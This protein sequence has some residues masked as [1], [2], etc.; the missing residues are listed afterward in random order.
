M[1]E[2]S[3]FGLLLRSL[4]LGANLTLEALSVR[5]GVSERTIGDLERGASTSPQRRTVDALA[6]GLGL[7]VAG[8]HAFLRAARARPRHTVAPPLPASVAPHRVFD[9][10]GRTEEIQQALEILEG[11]PASGG[12]RPALVISG[13]PGIGKT[14]GALEILARSRLTEL[15]TVFVSLDGFSAA[16]LTPLQIITTMLRQL[17]GAPEQPATDLETAA[18]QWRAA[19]EISP[20]RILLDNAANESQVRPIL[21]ICAGD[22]LVVTSRRSLAGLEGVR[23]LRFGPLRRRD[24]IALLRHLMPQTD[25]DID[26]LNEIASLCDDIPLALRVVGNRIASRPGWTVDDLLRRMRTSEDRLRLL[27]AGDL[28]VE[29]AISL[30]YEEL[31][32]RTAALFRW[33]SLIDGK[34]FTA[35]LAAVT[36]DSTEIGDVE[37]RLDDLTDLG[38]LEARGGDRYRLHDLLRLF[39][40]NRLGSVATDEEIEERRT[41]VGSWVLGTLERAG[42]WFEP[43]REPRGVA[44]MG[45][46]FITADSAG[47]WIRSEAEHWWPAYVDAAEHGQDDVVVDVADALHWFSDVWLAW[48]NWHRFFSLAVTSAQNLDDLRMEATQLGYV[49]WA[50]IVELGDRERAVL[51]GRAARSAAERAGDAG[52]IGWGN[53]YIGWAC[54]L[55]NRLDDAQA[56]AAAAV[57]AFSSADDAAGIENADLLSTMIKNARGEHLAAIQEMESTLAR[58]Q[59]DTEQATSFMSL[60]VQ[61]SAYLDLIHSYI[62]VGRYRDAVDASTTGM[63]IAR[64]LDDDA[65]VVM[66]LRRRIFAMIKAGDTDAALAEIDEALRMVGPGS[67][68]AYIFTRFRDEIPD[69]RAGRLPASHLE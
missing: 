12:H 7:D 11:D 60:L 42:A 51:T 36:I 68:Q 65:R 8:Q 38:L 37:F 5:S 50:E 21:S 66:M 14:T 28:A 1:T 41:H 27:V 48:G 13:A 32:P 61:S 33:I 55:L 34:T 52:Q 25:P 10:S 16:P 4:R 29:T 17:Q 63:R 53:Y 18:R 22:P 24:S 31:D 58:V 9:F 43:N 57:A 40:R 26:A 23:R 39:A 35:E 62:A 15:P 56:A 69:I 49:A 19:V 44:R 6:D 67:S 64:S 20:V 59:S 45:R 54:W 3:P 30:S 47:V 46:G 2:P